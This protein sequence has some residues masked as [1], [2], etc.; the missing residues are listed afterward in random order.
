MPGPRHKICCFHRCL[1]EAANDSPTFTNAHQCLA[2]AYWGKRSYPKVIEEWRVL[3]QLSGDQNES[4]FAATLEKGFRP[5]K[6][7]GALAK[8]I[9]ARRAQLNKVYSS[10]FEIVRLYA[11]LGDADQAFQWLN[12]AHQERDRSLLFLKT[13]PKLDP[14]RSDPRFAELVRKVACRSRK[15]RQGFEKGKV[16]VYAAPLADLPRD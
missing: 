6:W 3:S 5:A 14:L 15:S 13:E 4:E 7:K 2:Q 12:I 11:E 8:G 16:I 9:E 1:P 10:A